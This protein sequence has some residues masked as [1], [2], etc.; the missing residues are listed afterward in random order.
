MNDQYDNQPLLFSAAAGEAL[1]V[2]GIAV[3]EDNKK[4]LVAYARKLSNEA[5]LKGQ[6]YQSMDDVALLLHQNNVSIF[7]LGNSAGH[8]LYGQ[9][10]WKPHQEIR[11][12]REKAH[13]NKIMQYKFDRE[14]YWKEI[15][16]FEKRNSK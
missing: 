13:R 11:S 16:E 12:V 4:S 14:I 2:Q 6:I 7:A 15:A 10:W 3:A 1:K 5:A 8:L 9:P